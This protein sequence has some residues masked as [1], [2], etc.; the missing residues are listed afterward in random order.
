MATRAELDL[1]DRPVQLD[2]CLPTVP[3]PP[4]PLLPGRA[5]PRTP[6]ARASMGVR[7]DG[8][9]RLHQRARS[10]VSTD[11]GGQP[12][13]DPGVGRRE[14]LP[15]PA[16]PGRLP[17]YQPGGCP[18]VGDALSPRQYAGSPAAEMADGR[19]RAATAV[20]CLAGS[21]AGVPERLPHSACS[22]R[23][24]DCGWHRYSALPP[25]R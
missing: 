11:R 8:A 15:V 16:L 2:R 24:A 21:G 18:V 1:L 13:G 5:S 19:C 25:L 3:R 20:L 17:G 10:G 23:L 12:D 22:A 9:D 7:A 6:L 14:Q 4:A